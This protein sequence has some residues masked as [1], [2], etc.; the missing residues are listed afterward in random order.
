MADFDFDELDRAVNN[1]LGGE[2]PRQKTTP[3][4][5]TPTPT[6]TEETSQPETTASASPAPAVRRSSGRFMDVVHPSSDMRHKT[7]DLPAQERAAPIPVAESDAPAIQPAVKTA[8]PAVTIPE[9]KDPFAFEGEDWAKPLESPFIPNAVVEKRPLG[10]DIQ[11][12]SDYDRAETP[13]APATP[14][15]QPT[16]ERMPDPID[17]AESLM[18]TEEQQAEETRTIE[19]DL[20]ETL[21]VVENKVVE[22]EPATQAFGYGTG[23]FQ[24]TP[25]PVEKTAT[26]GPTSITQQYTEQTSSTT[27]SGAIYDTTAY[28]QPLAHAARKKSGAWVILWI[29]LL[30]V[31]GGGAGAAVY[32]FVLPLI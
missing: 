11:S 3:V 20:E 9:P 18:S 21:E 28:H 15:P 16:Y 32:F 4:T 23:A 31:L 7:N 24:H 22:E 14:T 12:T 27:E 6:P 2:T 8:E 26:L 13:E 10:G 30:I 1:A 19:T 17:F 29:I 25:T 5:P